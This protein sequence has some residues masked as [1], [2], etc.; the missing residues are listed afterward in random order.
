[1]EIGMDKLSRRIA[2]TLLIVMVTASAAAADD[3]KPTPLIISQQAI[4]QAIATAPRSFGVPRQRAASS[5]T[6][7]GRRVAWT[8]VGAVG[9]FFG[10]A[11]LGSTIDRAVHDCNCDDPGIVGFLIGM[12]VGAVAGGVAGFVLSK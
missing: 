11:L 3:R 4:Q 12:P 8:V 9:G 2:A 6:H 5:S 7:T 1:M 10:G